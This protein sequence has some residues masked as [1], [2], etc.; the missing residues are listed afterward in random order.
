MS[1]RQEFEE[2]VA[3]E[4]KK[5]R[6]AESRLMQ[7]AMATVALLLGGL[8]VAAAAEADRAFAPRFSQNVQGAITFTANT[9]MTC[10][11]SDSRCPA[12]QAGTGSTLNN[13]SFT[14]GYVD[15]DSDPSTFDS[16]SAQLTVPDS[17]DILFAGLYYGGQTTAGTGGQRA[18]NAGARGTVLMKTPGS[19]S[20][21][22]LTASVDDSTTGKYAAFVDVTS[23]VSTARSG[24]YTVANIQT[25]TGQDRAGGWTLVVAVRS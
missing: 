2:R 7:V 12:A 1:G 23:Q 19:A 9:V 17:A 3:V 25:G 18:P 4:R 5:R 11:A 10:P 21:Q 13:N 24:S 15:V 6:P 16:S 22:T 8:T 20:Y 14:M